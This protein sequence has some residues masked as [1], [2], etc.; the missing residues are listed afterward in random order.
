MRLTESG[1]RSS[2]G[3]RACSSQTSLC[4]RVLSFY[5]EFRN[6]ESPLKSIGHLFSWVQPRSNQIFSSFCK[7]YGREQD[8]LE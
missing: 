5:E 4:W 2:L 3:E 7:T 6:V 8:C 1:S